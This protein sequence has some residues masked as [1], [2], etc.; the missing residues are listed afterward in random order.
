MSKKERIERLEAEVAQLRL[1]IEMLKSNSWRIVPYEPYQ[2]TITWP[3]P[4]MPIII[5]ESVTTNSE[6]DTVIHSKHP[7]TNEVWVI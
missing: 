3:P 1:E 6:N 4:G 5:C 7:V 2:P